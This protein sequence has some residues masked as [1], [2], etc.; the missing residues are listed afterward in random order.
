M[1]RRILFALLCGWAA[2]VALQGG[3]RADVAG[4][5]EKR[6]ALVI[7]NANYVNAPRLANPVTDARAVADT[8]RRLGVTVIEGYDLTFNEMRARLG[9]FSSSLDGTKGAILYYAG[10]GVA[11]GGENYLLPV[12]ISV[13][14]L[15]D[16]DLNAVA[17]S[18][19]LRQ[20]K[21]DERVN[22]VILDACRENPFSGNIPAS[23]R[24]AIAARGLEPVNGELARG[25]LVAFATDPGA[26]AFDGP[27][28]E[29]SPFTRALLNHLGDSAT[30]VELM[31]HRVRD[32]VWKSTGEKQL[33]W[34][35]TSIIGDFEFNP[36][37]AQPAAPPPPPVAV[38]FP[39]PSGQQQATENLLWAS[40]D[41]S[42]TVDDYRTYLDAFPN[43]VFAPLAKRRVASLTAGASAEAGENALNLG[44]T[45]RY[46]VQQALLTLHFELGTPDGAFGDQ[47]RNAL[48]AWQ[49]SQS[50][51]QTGYLD[52][53]Q[54][55][56]LENVQQEAARQMQA[57]TA[58]AAAA[59]R[60]RS[61][62]PQRPVRYAP[63]PVKESPGPVKEAPAPNEETPAVAARPARAS[64]KAAATAT[65]GQSGALEPIQLLNALSN[66]G[67]DGPGQSGA[68]HNGR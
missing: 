51:P 15:A 38:P 57:A 66:L 67:A 26:I 20:M 56:A 46:T 45:Q 39:A 24:S 65:G 14:T 6:V 43:G 41:R 17:L 21:R 7:G 34:V 40:A 9:E 2:L 12:D 31:M 27:P 33:P 22:I 3:A 63:V 42:G 4:E 54:L 30:P 68:G 18:L 19:V 37:E 59:A 58:A 1:Q 44:A 11:L 50:L 29:H 48:R 60:L 62:A 35:N 52:A 23:S 64:A 61:V 53:P 25:A 49:K 32:E 10:H 28:G 36:R 13:R 47:T 8:L 5:R 55:A 16:F